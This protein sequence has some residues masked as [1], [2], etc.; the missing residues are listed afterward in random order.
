MIF[1]N[2]SSVTSALH[3]IS[4]RHGQLQ[5]VITE[6]TMVYLVVLLTGTII[7]ASLLLHSARRYRRSKQSL[8]EA[9]TLAWG[10]VGPLVTRIERAER[11]HETLTRGLKTLTSSQSELIKHLE[12]HDDEAERFTTYLEEAFKNDARLAEH[13][14]AVETALR[15]PAQNPS[16]TVS[17]PGPSGTLTIPTA[18]GSIVAR[19][20]PTELEVLHLLERDGGLPAPE[21][22]R[23]IGK[24]RE[25]TA[26]LMKALFE[27]GYVERES[28]RIPFRYRLTEKVRNA[29][30]S[31]KQEGVVSQGDASPTG[32]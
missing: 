3:V 27:Q 26:R 11:T 5:I 17:I 23:R 24:S 30:R 13:L 12:N 16:M 19:L 10:L 15:K 28:G 21:I 1:T 22:G 2:H 25:H 31:S 32:A 9:H 6:T 20:T 7:S 14:A 18:D 8:E 4:T 29:L